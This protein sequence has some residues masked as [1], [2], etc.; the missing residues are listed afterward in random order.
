MRENEVVKSRRMCECETGPS[1]VGQ[2]SGAGEWGSMSQL[3][4]GNWLQMRGSVA[5]APARR[6]SR[7]KGSA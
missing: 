5:S 6:H 1:C 3:L 7:I 4:L 2:Q